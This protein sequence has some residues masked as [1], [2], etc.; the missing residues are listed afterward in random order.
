MRSV[1]D[2]VA[3][4]DARSLAFSAVAGAVVPPVAE[5]LLGRVAVQLA[6]PFVVLLVEQPVA[7]AAVELV[8]HAAVQPVEPS[9]EPPALPVVADVVARPVEPVA[10]RLAGLSAALL[11]VVAIA[12]AVGAVAA[13]LRVLTARQ[14]WQPVQAQQ[15]GPVAE[16]QDEALPDGPGRL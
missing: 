10:G 5:P 16:Q 13:H 2:T 3:L 15:V 14:G 7:A 6:A 9:A 4:Q 11:A 8:V 12:A 1:I